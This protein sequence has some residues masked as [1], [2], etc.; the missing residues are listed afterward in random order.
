MKIPALFQS[1]LDGVLSHPAN[2]GGA[3]FNRL[4]SD[5][6]LSNRSSEKRALS[7]GGKSGEAVQKGGG[8]GRSPQNDDDDDFGM[9]S[10]DYFQNYKADSLSGAYIQ[11]EP[12]L[13][14]AW[15][16]IAVNILTRNIA[17]AS[18][19]LRRG[20][21]EVVSGPLYELF[22]RPNEATSRYDLW[23]ETAAW[24]LLE[25]EAFWWFGPEYSS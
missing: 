5:S 12:Y 11:A 6:A 9:T 4:L 16:H 21:D 2:S 14:N 25:G 10:V 20:G 3:L 23:K 13:I 17:R 18:F 7:N 8:G 19:V 24:W 22:R 1:L 15:V